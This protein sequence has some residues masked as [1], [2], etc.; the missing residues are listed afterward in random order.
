MIRKV[1]EADPLLC[2]KC[3]GQMRITAFIEVHKVIDM[4][5]AHLEL[6][7]EAE[8]P[9]SPHV[10]HGLLMPAWEREEYF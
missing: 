2:P 1:Y 4:I 8:R 10:Q 3:G 9:P 6:T 7:F 5:I